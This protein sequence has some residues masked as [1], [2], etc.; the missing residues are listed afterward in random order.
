MNIINYQQPV[1]QSAVKYVQ[2][3]WMKG[4]HSGPLYDDYSLTGT[5]IEGLRQ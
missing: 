3:L 1:G 4:P 2:E 5:F